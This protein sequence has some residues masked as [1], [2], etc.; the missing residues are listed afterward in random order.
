MYGFI[1]VESHWRH[2]GPFL[3]SLSSARDFI[4]RVTRIMV[5]GCHQQFRRSHPTLPLPRVQE[6]LPA[7][8]S[9]IKGDLSQKSPTARHPSLARISSMSLPEP[10]TGKGRSFRPCRCGFVVSCTSERA[11]SPHSLSL[12]LS[13]SFN[14]G[15]VQFTAVL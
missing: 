14:L 11:I 1:E 9:K 5:A 8:S 2:S 6:A 7:T 4:F 3:L 10:I 13:L 15:S 12:N